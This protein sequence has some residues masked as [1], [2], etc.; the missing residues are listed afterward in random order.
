MRWPPLRDH[1]VFAEVLGPTPVCTAMTWG[2]HTPPLNFLPFERGRQLPLIPMGGPPRARKGR[3][4]EPR[5][6][7][8]LSPTHW[9]AK[10]KS[11]NYIIV[12]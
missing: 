1:P 8:D 10:N 2:G 6:S 7:T 9:R 4:C 11:K 3:L 5:L 12:Y